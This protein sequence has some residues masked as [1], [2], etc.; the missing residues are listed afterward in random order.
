MHFI[1]N[2]Y[3]TQNTCTFSVKWLTSYVKIAK[4]CSALL[5]ILGK[6]YRVIVHLGI[7]KLHFC[8]IKSVEIG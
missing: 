8:R 5:S 6:A 4:F 3:K 1:C 2:T 7:A